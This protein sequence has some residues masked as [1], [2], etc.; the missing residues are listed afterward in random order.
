MVRVTQSKVC[1]HRRISHHEVDRMESGEAAGV[2]NIER[3]CIHHRVHIAAS[4]TWVNR[5][6]Q[7][8]SALEVVIEDESGSKKEFLFDAAQLP[9]NNCPADD[10]IR[11]DDGMES[12]NRRNRSNTTTAEGPRTMISVQQEKLSKNHFNSSNLY[13]QSVQC[14]SV[15]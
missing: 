15:M 1:S 8:P 12:N 9:D 5:E 7:S 6:S 2:G 14:F 13:V 3:A 4:D 11:D 10:L